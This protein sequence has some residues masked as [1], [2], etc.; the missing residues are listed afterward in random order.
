MEATGINGRA[1]VLKPSRWTYWLICAATSTVVTEVLL[2]VLGMTGILKPPFDDWREEMLA[3]ALFMPFVAG[4]SVLRSP[5][6]ESDFQNWP[7]NPV[8]FGLLYGLITP[9]LFVLLSVG[10]G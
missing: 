1:N 9:T 8:A 3:M 5:P 2:L 6:D 7:R 10:P 4:L